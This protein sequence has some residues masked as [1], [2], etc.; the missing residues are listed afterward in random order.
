MQHCTDLLLP[1][2]VVLCI[3]PMTP[4]VDRGEISKLNIITLESWLHLM[5]DSG[6]H[7]LPITPFTGMSIEVV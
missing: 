7:L 4:V 1:R 5:E 3:L 2:M 6:K